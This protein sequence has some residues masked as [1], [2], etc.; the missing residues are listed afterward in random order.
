MWWHWSSKHVC[1]SVVKHVGDAS[2]MAGCLWHSWSVRTREF[3]VRSMTSIKRPWSSN[4]RP[5]FRCFPT[6]L[7]VHLAADDAAHSRLY[8][9]A[10]ESIFSHLNLSELSRISAT[11]K[12]WSDAVGSMRPIG[13][14]RWK[15]KFGSTPPLAVRLSFDASR[16]GN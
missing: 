5:T 7:N 14:T 10:L 2:V 13:G 4:P 8:K 3:S 6:Q 15:G 9:H 16:V 12:D 11:C 1:V